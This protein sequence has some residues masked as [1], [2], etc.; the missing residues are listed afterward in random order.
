MTDAIAPNPDIVKDA[1]HAINDLLGREAMPKNPKLEERCRI[2][3]AQCKKVGE[4]TFAALS[5]ERSKEDIMDSLR[6]IARGT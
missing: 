3:S 2:V 5:E 1:S 6:L 4:V